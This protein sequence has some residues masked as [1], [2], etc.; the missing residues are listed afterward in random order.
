M[1]FCFVFKKF[2]KKFL[3]YYVNFNLEI[4]QFKDKQQ[5]KIKNKVF[6]KIFK[7]IIEEINRIKKNKLKLRAELEIWQRKKAF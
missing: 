4:Y 3:Y 2:I 6:I 1:F 7:N 5:E